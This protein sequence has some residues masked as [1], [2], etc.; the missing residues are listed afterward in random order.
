[1]VT[2]VLDA[3]KVLFQIVVGV[4]LA[5]LLLYALLRFSAGFSDRVRRWIDALNAWWANLFG[6]SATADEVPD[7]PRRVSPPRPFAAFAD[8]FGDGTA[9]GRDDEDLTRYSFA[10]LEAWAR[11]HEL[12]KL[13]RVAGCRV[14][15]RV[16][17]GAGARRPRSQKRR[18]VGSSFLRR[19]ERSRAKA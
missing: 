13:E 16:Q 7:E 6:R 4:V 18:A 15:Q 1:M 19:S 3:L 11:Q 12:G 10:A 2:N 5:L 17:H 8:P 9:D 14:G